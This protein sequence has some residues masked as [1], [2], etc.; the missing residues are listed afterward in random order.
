MLVVLP[1]AAASLHIG[2]VFVGTPEH[3]AIV[4]APAS[5]ISIAGRVPDSVTATWLE[6]LSHAAIMTLG[7]YMVSSAHASSLDRHAGVEVLLDGG[8]GRSAEIRAR[9]RGT[10]VWA[11]GCLAAAMLVLVRWTGAVPI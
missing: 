2:A 7:I 5:A 10:M 11:A 6:A 3:P 9:S 1:V 4:G 8:S